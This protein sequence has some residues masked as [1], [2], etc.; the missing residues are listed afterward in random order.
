[1]IVHGESPLLPLVKRAG[2]DASQVSGAATPGGLPGSVEL[3][4]GAVLALCDGTA[5]AVLASATASPV[6]VV[7]R[8][9]DPA[10]AKA[11]AIAASPDCP[12][13]AL[14][15]A[16]GLLQAAG[17]DVFVIGDAPGLI[18][19]RT[20]AMLANLAIDAVACG[21]ASPDDIDSAMRLGVSYPL[22]P[23][24]CADQWGAPEVLAILDSLESWYRDGRY[25][26]SPLLRLAALPGGSLPGEE[27]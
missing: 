16:T 18:V 3:P 23:L 21:V 13:S 8:V 9:L 4:S 1:M 27:P 6:I 2:V 20:V 7:D 11:I 14:A 12:R 19:T 24:A 17:L 22:G 25:R 10:T 15:E 26:P 5:A